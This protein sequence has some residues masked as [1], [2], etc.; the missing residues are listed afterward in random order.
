MV[1]TTAVREHNARFA[2]EQ[3]SGLVC[4]F[5]GGT[6]GIGA[7]TLEKMVTQLHQSTFYVLGRS[8]D[9]FAA[10]R[11]KL[12]ALAPTNKIVFVHAQVSLIRDVDAVCKRI[13]SK[14]QKAD[15]LYM[16][17]GLVPLNG[18]ECKSFS[19]ARFGIVWHLLTQSTDT[20]EGLETC[21]AVSYYCR[22]R[23]I[24]NLLPLLRQS[25]SPRVQSALN[26]GEEG[27]I[28][29]NDLG[30]DNKWTLF[31]VINHTTTMMTLALE[32]LGEQKENERMC[33]IHCYPGFVSTNFFA[34]LTP[35]DSASV[36]WRTTLAG[37]RGFVATLMSLFAMSPEQCGERQSYLLTS[38]KFG[39]GAWRINSSDEEVAFPGV[40]KAYREGSLKEQIWEHTTR[41]FEKALQNDTASGTS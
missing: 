31:G 4:V 8:E 25:P 39:P 26:G 19:I 14:E 7:G 9:R 23:L 13:A 12:E 5:T 29:I 18:A 17:A 24:Y 36:L 32:Y 35:P 38:D 6:S 3:H 37:I 41:I 15:Y 21:F 11:R 33:F 2:D 28:D 10:Q 16:S 34:R 40:L 20:H 30:L 27:A 22:I 1:T